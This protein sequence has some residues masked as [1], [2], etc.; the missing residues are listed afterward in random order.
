MAKSTKKFYV[1]QTGRK[2]DGSVKYTAKCFKR[3]STM[4]EAEACAK[5]MNDFNSKEKREDMYRK[6]IADPAN[7]W[8]TEEWYETFKQYEMFYCTYEAK[9]TK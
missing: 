9:E 6:W 5:Q 8:A 3:F 7:A 1:T 2:Y 4:E